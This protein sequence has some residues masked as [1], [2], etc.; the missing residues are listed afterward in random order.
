M[1]DK[2]S[3]AVIRKYLL[4]AAGEIQTKGVRLSERLYV[5]EPFNESQKCEIAERRRA[6]LALL[7][8]PETDVLFKMALVV[9]EFKTVETAPYGRKVWIKHMPDCP[10]FIDGKSWADRTRVR[11][12]VRGARRGHEDQAAARDVR[13]DL[14]QRE[15]TYQIDTASFM[16]V[17]DNWIPLEGVH[18]IDLIYH[19]TEQSRRFMKPLSYDASSAAYFPNALLL[20]TGDAPA[21]LHIIS[22][23]MDAKER[24][25]K[26]KAIQ[27]TDKA[28]AWIWHTDQPIPALPPTS[29]ALDI[30]RA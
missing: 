17:T 5:P 24:S 27:R 19:L 23:F 16:L 12:V 6:H 11:T 29:H 18:E 21:A 3:S 25:V 14:R 10:L 20:D 30:S 13:F 26:D 15:H 4:E 7:H 22:N 9:G 28:K 8:S 2:R 1:K